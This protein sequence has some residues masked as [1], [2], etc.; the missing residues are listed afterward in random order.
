MAKAKGQFVCP[1]CG[2]KFKWKPKMAGRKAACRCGSRIRVPEAPGAEAELLAAASRAHQ[3]AER[4]GVAA[5]G[6]E[7]PTEEDPNQGSTYELHSDD[8]AAGRRIGGGKTHC[9]NCNQ[10]LKP[11]AVLC[12]GCGFNLQ[13]GEKIQTEV[14][15]AVEVDE[16]AGG[17]LG[18]ASRTKAGSVP[19][20]PE[21]VEHRFQDVHLPII[22]GIGGVAVVMGGG[23]LLSDSLMEGIVSGAMLFAIELV[24]MLPLMLI[25]LFVAAYLVGTS[26][27]T[28]G[29]ALL[30]LTGICLGPGAVGDLVAAT[31]LP[32]VPG[33]FATIG[34]TFAIYLIFLGIPLAL[35]FD[36]DFHETS[37]TVGTMIA[38]RLA[39]FLFV[40]TTLFAMA[41]Q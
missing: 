33:L 5:H 26:F 3:E 28:L 39:A 9:P 27:G 11:G 10:P 2:G 7:S 24:V 31:V 12:V 20:A 23:I 13:Q 15:D 37:M 16:G 35:M 29:I 30:K 18:G 4:S 41:M 32:Y 40:V 1:D 22:F 25:S 8:S 21:Q 38:V 34:I 14:A 19:T 17:S 6:S 36:L